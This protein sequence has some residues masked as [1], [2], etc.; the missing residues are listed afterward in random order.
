MKWLK[1]DPKVDGEGICE[2]IGGWG[3]Y[4]GAN[5]WMRG[6]CVPFSILRGYFRPFSVH[7]IK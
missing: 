5:R 4:F 3:G 2:P 1:L 7:S 6:S